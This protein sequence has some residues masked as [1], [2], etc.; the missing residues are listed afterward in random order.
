MGRNIILSQ[1]KKYNIQDNYK[2]KISFNN[3]FISQLFLN[4]KIFFGEYSF[5]SEK[6]LY[7]FAKKKFWKFIS[8]SLLIHPYDYLKTL[9][10]IIIGKKLNMKKNLTK[11]SSLFITKKIAPYF[12]WEIV[13]NLGNLKKNKSFDLDLIF[14]YGITKTNFGN[15]FLQQY[16]LYKVRTLDNTFYNRTKEPILKFSGFL[17]IK[18]LERIL[19]VI[20]FNLFKLKPSNF[21]SVIMNNIGKNIWMGSHNSLSLEEIINLVI[22]RLKIFSMTIEMIKTVTFPKFPV[23]HSFWLFSNLKENRSNY[24]IFLNITKIESIFRKNKI[25]LVEKSFPPYF[26][27]LNFIIEDF[28][29][30]H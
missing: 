19:L 7:L 23:L 21:L 4:H 5:G 27:S 30:Y 2:K 6:N 20:S 12:W 3:I 9:E 1:K 22:F 29:L 10:L 14:L 17:K 18:Y 26:S 11:L 16:F 15:Y 8:K 13:L 25:N 24:F 28:F